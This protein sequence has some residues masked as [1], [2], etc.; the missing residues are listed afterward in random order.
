MS[1]GAESFLGW[2]PGHGGVPGTSTGEVQAM[3][4]RT[5]AAGTAEVTQVP[6]NTEKHTFSISTGSKLNQEPDDG[7][8]KLQGQ[9]RRMPT[10][11]QRAP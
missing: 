11:Q 5:R 4:G 10:C 7:A 9:P 2:K 6:R 8:Q 3:A 1:G